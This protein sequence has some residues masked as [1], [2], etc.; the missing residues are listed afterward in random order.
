MRSMKRV[1]YSLM[2]LLW[3]SG[4]TL[5]AQDKQTTYTVMFYNAENLFDVYNDPN[6]L[7]DEFTP[8][9]PKVWT[10]TK[11]WKKIENTAE[12]IHAIAQANRQFP[13]IIGLSE[14]E[15][16]LV[17][18]DLVSEQ[19]LAG[20]NYQIVH[21]DSPEARGVDVALLY[22]PDQFDYLWSEP[23]RP[24]IPGRPDFKTRDILAVAGKIEGELF[25]FFVNHWSSRR[26]GAHSSEYLRC[27]NA[28]TLRDYADSL[29]TVY[30]DIKLV[31]M[32]D[33]NDNP[34]DK[35]L[36]E[37]LGAVGDLDKLVDGGM[38]NPFY[39]LFEDGYG[40]TAY[41]DAWSLF[42]NLVV[43]DNLIK[44]SARGIRL[45]PS[46][47]RK[48]RYYATIFKR[49][50]LIQ[51]KGQYK[52]YPWR[53]YSGNAFLGGYSDHFPVFITLGIEH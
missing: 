11:Y 50:F 12:V 20:A 45:L 13:A 48:G 39:Q 35:S 24:N 7:D 46:K 51:Q 1:L 44:E 47:Q 52:N 37:V 9:G 33:M 21:Y 34:T 16:R 32:G 17:L 4:I 6:V 23:I 15:N 30:P 42:D 31:A 19:R 43:S 27:G 22:R 8:E 10:E 29:R 2:A 41:Q 5:T 49:P 36:L 40:T 18:D 53:T 26:G 3:L 28:Q 25:C 14:I 38:F